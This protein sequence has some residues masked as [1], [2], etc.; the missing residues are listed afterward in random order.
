MPNFLNREVLGEGSAYMP[1]VVRVV[2]LYDA[3]VNCL[4]ALK[5]INGWIELSVSNKLCISQTFS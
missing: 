5:G 4:L 3:S 1:P 2:D